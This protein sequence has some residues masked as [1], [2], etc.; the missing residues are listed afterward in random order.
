MGLAR[1]AGLPVVVVGD[2]DRGGVF[3]GVL[4]HRRPPVCRRPAAGGRLPGQQVPRR[5]PPAAARARPARRPHRPAHAGRAALAGRARA[6]R[7]GLPQPAH[8][9]SAGA[10]RARGRRPADLGGPASPA[11]ERHRPR[12][13]GRRA[14]RAG[15]LRHPPRG[16]GRRRPGDPP[17]H[18]RHRRRPR[19]AA[20]DRAGRRGAAAGRR[21]GS[22][23]GHL[24]RLADAGADDHRRRGV[25]GRD[26]ARPGTA[27][28]PT[29]VS[30]R[31]RR[32]AGRPAPLS[33]SRCAATRSTTA[34]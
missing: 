9:R 15:A 8:R 26:G 12:R 28:R 22:G 18:P 34:C 1:A 33:G 25:A 19:L 11:V 3:A 32:S 7:R 23:P 5:R 14:G 17:R 24:R 6:G 13:P 20:L 4:R 10:S 30:G 2:I 29:S 27:A 31:T 16:T 21:R